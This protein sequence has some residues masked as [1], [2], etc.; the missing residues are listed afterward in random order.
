MGRKHDDS[1]DLAGG[2]GA[3]ATMVAAARAAASRG[4]DAVAD[5]AFAEGLVRAV[6]VGVFTK[7]AA[8]ELSFADIGGDGG[9]AWMPHAFGI[10]ARHYDDFWTSASHSGIRQM[11]NVASGLDTRAYRLP[12]PDGTIVYEIDMPRVI[13]FKRTTLARLGAVPKAGLHTIGAD[14]RQSWPATLRASGFDPSVP[15]AWMAEG[16]MIGYLPA[17]AQ[18]RLLDDI[19]ALSAPS[20]RLAADHVPG[21]F[22]VLSEQ[23]RQIG[24]T[25]NERGF[26]VDFNN[27]YFTGEHNN[28]ENYLQQRG[29][30][31]TSATFPDLFANAGIPLPQLDF[32]SGANGVVHITAIRD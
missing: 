12:W 20:S 28:A 24:K 25:W 7:L 2:V 1:W 27:L 16:L 8:G 13:E 18:D 19:T 4:A 11:V 17:D 26:D 21:S 30:H 5:D 32:G 22:S 9:S 29:W 6:G 14:L 15:T 3:T 10:R 31:T 23:I